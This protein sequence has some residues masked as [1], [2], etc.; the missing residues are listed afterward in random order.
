MP[1]VPPAVEIFGPV[2]L[3]VGYS[4]WW[5]YTDPETEW[6]TQYIRHH[7]DPRVRASRVNRLQFFSCFGPRWTFDLHERMARIGSVWR[8]APRRVFFS[9]EHL[10]SHPE[11][12]AWRDHARATDAA[13]ILGS[14]L[15]CEVG[16]DPRYLRFPLWLLVHFSP[17][18]GEAQQRRRYRELMHPWTH[19]KAGQFTRRPRFATHVSRHDDPS[20]V[21]GRMLDAFDQAGLGPIDCPSRF[22]HNDDRLHREF[23]DNKRAYLRDY[24]FNLCPENS[25]APGYVTEK[26]FDSF[27]SGTVPVYRGAGGRPEPEVVDPRAVIFWCD[28]GPGPTEPG[29]R[30]IGADA[31]ARIAELERHPE[32]YREFAAQPRLRPEGEDW[33]VARFA[34]LTERLVEVAVG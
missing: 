27:H 24:R 13:L 7:V 4:H 17:S 14:G 22:R 26:L 21:R 33:V 31:L 25:D 28:P 23:A 9:G 5:A 6:F 2:P 8:P 3:R 32:R 18:W 11:Y 29:G 12:R 20:G 15:P 34:A 1:S 30:T 16:D 10:H 19:P